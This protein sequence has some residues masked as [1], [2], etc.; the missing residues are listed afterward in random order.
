MSTTT[1]AAVCD[2]AAAAKLVFWI[3][4]IAGQSCD[5]VPGYIVRRATRR[6]ERLAGRH[7]HALSGRLLKD[8]GITRSEIDRAVKV[9]TRTED[10]CQ[11]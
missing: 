7:L 1:Q 10:N 8:I 3:K 6:S 9:G 4:Q 5:L 2:R 11:R